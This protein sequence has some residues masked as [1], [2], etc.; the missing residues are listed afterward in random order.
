M[1]A[2]ELI[3]ASVVAAAPSSQDIWLDKRATGQEL[4]VTTAITS[5]L[6]AHTHAA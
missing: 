4:I 2:E 5:A 3:C 1:A 6:L